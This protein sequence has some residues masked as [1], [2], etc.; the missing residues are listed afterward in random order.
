MKKQFYFEN[1]DAEVCYTEDYW[2]ASMRMDETTEIDV[3]QA[4]PDK[5]KGIFWCKHEAFCGDDSTDTCGKQCYAYAPRN[6][7][8]GC[9]KYY[10]TTI[11]L[12]GDLVTLKL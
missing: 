9:C 11:Y 6:G 5:E 8:S 10:T 12:H 1:E 7:K 4:V 2:K 3:M